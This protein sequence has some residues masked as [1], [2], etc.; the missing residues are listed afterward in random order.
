MSVEQKLYVWYRTINNTPKG[1]PLSLE[2]SIVEEYNPKKPMQ[3]FDFDW[4]GYI[5]GYHS[6]PPEGELKLPAKLSLVMKKV[7][8]PKFDYV[9]DSDMYKVVSKKLYNLL[10]KHGLTDK[11]EYADLTL[12]DKQGNNVG[13]QEYCLLRLSFSD[14]ECFDF[15][16]EKVIED[17][18][19]YPKIKLK[20]DIKKNVFFLNNN[21][22]GIF[23]DCIIFTDNVKKEIEKL[24]YKPEI[25]SIKKFQEI[26]KEELDI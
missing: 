1:E 14:D 9:S 6:F 15:G 3:D 19:F 25:Y 20:E 16:K 26:Y 23:D 21:D 17:E 22:N 11:Y 4:S 10:V 13:Q 2:T 24:C 8:E 5:E 12:L 18:I 7:K